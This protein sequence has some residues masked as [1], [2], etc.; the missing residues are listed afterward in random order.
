[1]LLLF[2]LMLLLFS[3]QVVSNSLQPHGLATPKHT[4]LLYPSPLNWW[5]LPTISSSVV[6]FSSCL[7]SFPASGFFPVSQML[8]S[9]GQSIG[10]SGTIYWPPTLEDETLVLTSFSQSVQLLSHVQL[11]ATAWTAACQASLSIAN[12]QSLPKLMSIESVM[13]SNHLILCSPLLLLPSIFLSIRVFSNESARHI[14]WPKYWSFSFNI[15][16][17]L[18]I[19]IHNSLFPSFPSKLRSQ[20]SVKLIFGS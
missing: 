4:R 8:A 5:Y 20:V 10:A 15:S 19:T 14:R 18:P 2:I 17:S 7:Q 3:R 16:P 11:F 13:P 6:P 12:S 1:M 9:G